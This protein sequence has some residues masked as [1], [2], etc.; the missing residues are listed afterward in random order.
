VNRKQ[1][2]ERIYNVFCETFTPYEI[3]A[4]PRLGILFRVI[5]GVRG[6][7]RKIESRFLDELTILMIKHGNR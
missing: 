5:Q 3:N 7:Y 1:E 6:T 2:N 4:N